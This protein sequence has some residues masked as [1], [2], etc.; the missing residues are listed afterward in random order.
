VA[1]ITFDDCT[2][3]NWIFAL[4]ELARRKMTATFFAVTGFLDP[5]APACGPTRAGRPM[6]PLLAKSCGWP[7]KANVNGS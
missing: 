2:V 7:C 5:G 4:P 1:V 3:D 6:S